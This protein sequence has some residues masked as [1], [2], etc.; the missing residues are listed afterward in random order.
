M[1]QP[2]VSQTAEL[3]T[4]AGT[5]RGDCIICYSTYDL[6]GHLP[7]RLYC[8]HTFCQACVCQLDTLATSSAGSPALSSRLGSAPPWD[9]SPTFPS[10]DAAAGAAAP[11]AGAPQTAPRSE[12]WPL[13]LLAGS[14]CL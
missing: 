9:P 11:S 2:E 14:C 6:T 13:L 4:A 3:G 12:F 10:P 7:R 1:L 5:Q 8:G